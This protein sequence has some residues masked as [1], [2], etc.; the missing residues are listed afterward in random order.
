MTRSALATSDFYLLPAKPEPLSVVGI[1][2]LERRIAKL[3][4]SHEQEAKI[5]IKML[6][7]VFS[8][9][10]TNLL[11]GRYY[12]QVMHRVV[13]DFG[14][15]TICQSQIP[16]DV[17]VAKAVDSFMPVTLMSPGSAG[18]KSFMQLTE[19]LLRKL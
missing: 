5:N 3:K 11:T 18:A 2:L 1:Q 4:D 7:I 15:E 9:C 12:K 8:M 19:E 14:V 6:G 13:E 10:N 16:V 17:N